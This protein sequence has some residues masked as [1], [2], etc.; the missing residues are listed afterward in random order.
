MVWQPLAIDRRA[1]IEGIV[2]EIA[3]ALDGVAPV[4]CRDHADR[5]L[6]RSYLAEDDVV[7]DPEGVA[8]RALGQA[9]ATFA[10]T[11]TGLGLFG[12]AAGI[13]WTVAHIAGGEPARLACERL[14]AVISRGLAQRSGDYDLIGG[15]VGFGVYAL[16]TGEA[17]RPLAGHVL[18]HL[19]RRARPRSGGL[20]WHTAPDLLPLWQREHAPH[21]YWNLGLAHGLPGVIA[22]LARFITAEIEVDRAR[23][24]LEPAVAALLAAAPARDHGRYPGWQAGGPD[25][26]ACPAEVA[27][28]D[29]QR[30]R[31][32][33]CYNDLGVAM[34]LG[35]AA[36]AARDPGW[37]AEMHA[38]ARACAA[39]TFEDAQVFDAGI[40]HGAIGVAH[41]FD[42]LR[43]ATGDS[44]VAAAAR[45]WLDRALAMRNGQ[46]FAGFPS[47]TF[48]DGA[49]RWTADASIL[50]GAAG[51]ALVLHSMITEVEPAW[52]RLLL[53]DLPA[54]ASA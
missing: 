52:D 34:A 3:A 4:T 39:R 24:L 27:D 11:T 23:A 42:R 12:G 22:L 54:A 7:S 10:A 50:T 9:V 5:A 21:G 17:G 6:L 15:L 16:E 8:G 45:S 30:G 19:E 29:A 35:S 20:A 18:D 49:E 40:C 37:R 31:L 48:H 26:Q 47:R 43:Q 51:V 53:A 38:L 44:L 2:R 28:D 36:L 14:D 13:G 25:E 41:L 46:P 33:W 1:E 32:A